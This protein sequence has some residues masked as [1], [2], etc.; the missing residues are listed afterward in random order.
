MDTGPFRKIA[1]GVE[2]MDYLTRRKQYGKNKS[3][4]DRLR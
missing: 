3:R 2:K 4:I 1:H